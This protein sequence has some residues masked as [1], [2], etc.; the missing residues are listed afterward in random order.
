[1]A[2]PKSTNPFDGPPT[3]KSLTPNEAVL[4]HH[5]SFSRG[6]SPIKTRSPKHQTSNK[7]QDGFEDVTSDRV[8][9]E[10]VLERLASGKGEKGVETPK[11]AQTPKGGGTPKDVEHQK[12]KGEVMPN[13]LLSKLSTDT[14]ISAVRGERTQKAIRSTLKFAFP[15][16]IGG[17]IVWVTDYALN[18]VRLSACRDYPDR[19]DCPRWIKDQKG[20][21]AQYAKQARE[22]R[23]KKAAEQRKQ[24][25]QKQGG[26]MTS[27][28]VTSL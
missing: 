22:E 16:V 11:S 3:P 12:P 8:V 26:Y 10:K 15:M 23:E 7:S 25:E 6:L 18:A 2:P 13:R 1:M 5:D 17:A 14:P 24:T 19:P 9:K 28:Q 4:E 27:E 20:N 21:E